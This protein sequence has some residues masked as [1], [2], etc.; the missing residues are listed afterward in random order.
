[1]KSRKGGHRPADASA[2]RL[3][4]FLARLADQFT[5]V[6]KLPDLLDHVMTSLRDEIGFDSCSL[7]LA[8]ERD[9]QAF[10]I[11][12]AS[13]LRQPYL[14]LQVPA[15]RGLH[16]VVMGTKGPLYVPD[17]DADPRVFRREPAVKSGIYAPLVATGRVIG[18]LSAH[19][20]EPHAFGD[21]DL[22]LLTVVARYLAGAFEVARLHDQLKTAA[23][24]DTLTGLA[25]RRAFFDRFDAEL[26]RSARTGEALSVSLLD[27]NGLKAINDRYGHSIGDRAL[28]TAAETL[29]GNIRA[30]DLA[31]RVGGDEFTLL[32]PGTARPQAEEIVERIGV[33]TM[34]VPGANGGAATVTFA[35]GA[36][37]WPDD[38]DTTDALLQ[39]ADRRLYTMKH[40]SRPAPSPPQQELQ[41]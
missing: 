9:P 36:A 8:D 31:A 5:A 41:G 24:T 33:A 17:M 35:W 19:R 28:V 40:A 14:G 13:G 23:A 30:F 10:V 16:G 22:N 1:M 38:G 12:A 20:S 39:A 25:N 21:A 2:E 26:A 6:L 32:F 27:L 7:A 15:G 4:A 37:A 18:V 34:S 3:L 29:G 11:H